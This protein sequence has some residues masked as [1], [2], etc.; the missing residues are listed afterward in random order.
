[1]ADCHYLSARL[2]FLHGI[3]PVALH[4]GATAVEMYL[5]CLLLLRGEN[6]EFGHDL[7]KLFKK[8]E[9]NLANETPQFVNE[10]QKSY[11]EDKYP[12]AWNGDVTWKESIHD[13]DDLAQQLRHIIFNSLAEEE[14][15]SVQDILK[16]IMRQGSLIPHIADRYGV[17]DMRNVFLRTNNVFTKF[18]Y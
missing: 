9:I 18:I 16:I 6:P 7:K 15:K 12:D 11:Q 17:M 2:L 13:L 1:M 3:Y 14:K 10:L 5:K 4:D 8:A